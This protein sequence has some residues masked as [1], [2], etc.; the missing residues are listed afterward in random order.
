MLS[1]EAES[2][3]LGAKSRRIR[4]GLNGIKNTDQYA[5]GWKALQFG[6]EAS[7][8]YDGSIDQKDDEDKGSIIELSIPKKSLEITNGRILVNFGYFD[9]IANAEDSIGDSGSTKGWLAI[10][11]L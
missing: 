6:A 8:A 11:G 4:F 2:T 9:A 10:K 3:K 7:V 5:G 1:P